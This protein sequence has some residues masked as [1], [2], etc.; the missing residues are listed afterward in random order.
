[1]YAQNPCRSACTVLYQI[2]TTSLL[3]ALQIGSLNFVP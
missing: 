2:A 1:M 3:Y